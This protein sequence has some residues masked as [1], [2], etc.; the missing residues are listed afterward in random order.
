MKLYWDDGVEITQYGL[1]GK[2][3]PNFVIDCWAD[4]YVMVEWTEDELREDLR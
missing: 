2:L 3:P 1:W 4:M